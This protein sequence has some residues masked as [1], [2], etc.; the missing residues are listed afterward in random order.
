MFLVGAVLVALVLIPAFF[1][2]R[3][4]IEH[5]VDPALMVGH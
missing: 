4:K 2:P 1:L 5:Q 3:K